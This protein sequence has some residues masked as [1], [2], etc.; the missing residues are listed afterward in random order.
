MKNILLPALL[1][2]ATVITAQKPTRLLA[3]TKNHTISMEYKDDILYFTPA[4]IAVFLENKQNGEKTSSYSEVIKYVKF[5]DK[6]IA[7]KPEESN[8]KNVADRNLH[9]AL[10]EVAP[11][12][13]AKGKACDMIRSTQ[14]FNLAII[15]K[16]CEADPKKN[17]ITEKK[18]R[19][20]FSC[21]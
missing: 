13:L 18:G 6:E 4:D 11:G 1:L 7:Y 2:C 5:Y 21:D 12:M 20:I 8:F 17:L 9:K 3:K 19:V 16:P 15:A 14:K 10:V